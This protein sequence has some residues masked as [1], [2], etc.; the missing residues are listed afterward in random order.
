MANFP[1]EQF[2]PQPAPPWAVG[3]VTPAAQ[4]APMPLAA[5]G[6]GAW[7]PGDPA[8]I[9]GAPG[10]PPAPAPRGFAPFPAPGAVK[11][12]TP[13]D[14]ATLKSMRRELE[15]LEARRN[16]AGKALHAT[17]ATAFGRDYAEPTIEHIAEGLAHHADSI[18]D[19]LAPFDSGVRQANG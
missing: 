10:L 11:P 3:R 5:S 6:P 14:E 16:H 7:K 17:V 2:D 18:R 9:P 19:A 1:P 8:I 13:Q 12:W 4:P 15:S